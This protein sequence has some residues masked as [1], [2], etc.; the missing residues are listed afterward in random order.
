MR[1]ILTP[2]LVLHGLIHL[3]GVSLAWDGTGAKMA[4]GTLV[5]LGDLALRVAGVAWLIACLALLVAALGVAL[6]REWWR[7]SAIGALV[8]SQALIVLWW[9]DARAGTLANL[10]ILAVAA[11]RPGLSTWRAALRTDARV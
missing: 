10:L 9:P 11:W 8:L 3:L 1:W 4:G 2:V 5:P 6:G 7:A